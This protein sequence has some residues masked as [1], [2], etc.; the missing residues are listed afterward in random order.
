ME[1]QGT[2]EG[3]P[4]RMGSKPFKTEEHYCSFAY[5]VS[6]VQ[7]RLLTSECCRS[8]TFFSTLRGSF[9]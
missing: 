8:V 5:P 9:S 6:V 4:K 2:V 1:T 7:D 3:T